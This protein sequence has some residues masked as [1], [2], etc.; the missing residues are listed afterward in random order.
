MKI[1]KI[2]I[3]NGNC[4]GVLMESLKSLFGRI[5]DSVMRNGNDSYR[6]DSDGN[7]KGKF[8]C[9]LKISIQDFDN[10]DRLINSLDLFSPLDESIDDINTEFL[11]FLLLPVMRARYLDREARNVNQRLESIPI[12][13][14]CYKDYIEIYCHL[15]DIKNNF[16]NYNEDRNARINRINRI[17]EL[18]KVKMGNYK[19]DPGDGN[20]LFSIFNGNHSGNNENDIP[21]NNR[22]EDEEISRK[23][24][25]SQLEI[26]FFESLGQIQI[27]K[28]EL[29]ILNNRPCPEQSISSFDKFENFNKANGENNHFYNP[30]NPPRITRPPLV[31][32]KRQ[33]IGDGIFKEG[34]SQPTMTID[35]YLDLERQRGGIISSTSTIPNSF[36]M[37]N[38]SSYSSSFLS[39]IIENDEMEAENGNEKKTINKESGNV[40][41]DNDQGDTDENIAQFRCWDRFKDDNP[42]GSGNQMG[43][44]S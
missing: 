18:K 22:N 15:Y 44:Y 3:I 27:L 26:A 11:S 40:T 43:N 14:K 35:E 7:I 30:Q 6:S 39:S 38:H 23:F 19:G 28:T 37:N 10:C 12:I 17:K 25:S 42:R 34:W 16:D 20:S 31:I 9:L 33:S 2:E 13:L 32:S 21:E 1:I 41:K 5:A 36:S 24:W 8:S 4:R 29:N